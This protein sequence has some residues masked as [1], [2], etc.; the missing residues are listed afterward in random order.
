MEVQPR[1]RLKRSPPPPSP[2]GGRPVCDPDGDDHISALPEDMIIQILVRLR[3]ARAAAR[4]GVLS[5]R[6]RGL[7]A[8]LP[9]L[10]FRDLPT[11]KIIAALDRVGL[12]AAVSLLDI[13][14]PFFWSREWGKAEDSSAKSLLR[15]AA[16]VSPEELV[17]ILPWSSAVKPGRPVEIAMPCFRRATSIEL[18][19]CH[20]R[21]KPPPAGELPVLERLSLSGNIVDLGTMISRC[22]RLRVLSV[23]FRDADPDSLEAAL[24]SLEAAAALGLVVS[25]LR[26]NHITIR[27]MRHSMGMYNIGV[28]RF[29]SLLGAMARLSPQELVLTQ[30]YQECYNVDLPRFDR[31][32]SIEMNL[33]AVCFTVLPA[34]EFPALEKL[35]LEGCTIPDLCTLVTRCPRLRILRAAIDN[36]TDNLT[37]TVH[38]TSLQELYLDAHKDTECQGIDIVTPLLKQ[39][40]LKVKA[41]M[42]LS[43]SIATPMVEKVSLR[44]SYTKF[45]LLFGFLSLESMRL[46]TIECDKY[47]D[48]GLSNINDQEGASLQ[49]PRIHVLV[50]NIFPY[51][52]FHSGAALLNFADEMKKLLITNFSALELHLSTKGHVLGALMLRLLGMHQI[53]TAVQRLK[54]ILSEWCRISQTSKCLE[55]CLCNEPKNWRSQSISLTHLEEVKI[56]GFSGGSSEI[57]FITMAWLKSMWALFAS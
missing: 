1:R 57:D 11:G 12:P 10:I 41:D 46:E 4:T 26:I 15:A 40:N 13:R 54:V 31:T 39:L 42:D 52:I 23:T 27:S 21:L 33:Y 7:W 19:T 48:V 56:E 20:L 22:P 25:L 3:C 29:V 32:T 44:L 17:F 45:P 9:D 47:K 43:V 16:R 53:R 49:P 35:S 28:A 5:R 14:F 8:G 50:L 30:G 36:H 55:K 24:A 34:G 37:V 51:N 38:S 2:H 18:D 6:W